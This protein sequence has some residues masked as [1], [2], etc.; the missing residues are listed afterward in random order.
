[1]DSKQQ[2]KANTIDMLRKKMFIE[3]HRPD[4]PISAT[5]QSQRSFPSIHMRSTTQ[6]LQ[7]ISHLSRDVSH[8]LDSN[9]K[10]RSSFE[11]HEAKLHEILGIKH[12]SRKLPSSLTELQSSLKLKKGKDKQDEILRDLENMKLKISK[13]KEKLLQKVIS[14][15]GL[16]YRTQ[17]GLIQ[18]QLA[19]LY[20]QMTKKGKGSLTEIPRFELDLGAPSGRKEV[21]IIILWLETMVNTHVNEPKDITLEEKVKRAQ[22]IYTTCFKEV[23][24]QVSTH[25]LE[26]GILMQKIWNAQIDIYCAK[27]DTRILEIDDMKRRLEKFMATAGAKYKAQNDFFEKAV[28]EFKDVIRGKDKEIRTLMVKVEE[29]KAQAERDRA[30]YIGGM[31]KGSKSAKKQVKFEN[32]VRDDHETIEEMVIFNR[33]PLVLVGYYDDDGFFHKQKAIQPYK[34][35]NAVKFYK[36]EIVKVAEKFEKETEMIRVQDYFLNKDTQME[37]DFCDR[38]IQYPDERDLEIIRQHDIG[39]NLPVKKFVLNYVP[40]RKSMMPPKISIFDENMENGIGGGLM[41]GVQ[42]EDLDMRKRLSMEVNSAGGGT[43]KSLLIENTMIHYAAEG[44]LDNQIVNGPLPELSS[45]QEPGI[46][47]IKAAVQQKSQAK[48]K[49]KS[50]NINQKTSQNK[51]FKQKSKK[52]FVPSEK[53]SNPEAISNEKTSELKI[54]TEKNV[55]Q[56]E[57]DD[58]NQSFEEK[59][60]KQQKHLLNSEK[61]PKPHKKSKIYSQYSLKKSSR[62][63]SYS[64]E[65]SENDSDDLKIS[66]PHGKSPKTTN[67]KSHNPKA[68]KKNSE[69]LEQDDSQ[70]ITPR[71][72]P[73]NHKK[74][75]KLSEK[76]VKQPKNPLNSS[77]SSDSDYKKPHNDS[78]SSENEDN[79]LLRVAQKEKTFRKSSVPVSPKRD[80]EFTSPSANKAKEIPKDKWENPSKTQNYKDKTKITIDTSVNKHPNIHVTEAAEATED[81]KSEYCQV[82]LNPVPYEELSSPQVHSTIHHLRKILKDISNDPLRKESLL[83]DNT[84]QKR[85]S[86]LGQ[87]IFGLFPREILGIEKK[88]ESGCIQKILEDKMCQTEDNYE[89]KI[90]SSTNLQIPKAAAIDMKSKTI[91]NTRSHISAA[92]RSRKNH[93]T[94]PSDPF[95]KS[96]NNS[97]NLKIVSTNKQNKSL[98]MPDEFA[99]GQISKKLILSH[100]GQK[101]LQMIILEIRAMDKVRSEMSIKSLMKAINSVYLE[102][103]TLSKENIN[104]IK[105]ET[106]MILYDM[107]MNRYGLKIVAEN[108]FKQIVFSSYFYKDSY[109]RVKNFIRFLGLEDDYQV[110]DWN[111]YLNCIDAIEYCN[112]GKNIFNEDTAVDHYSMLPRVIQCVHTIFDGKLP[113]NVIEKILEVVQNMKIEETQNLSKRNMNKNIIES[114]NTDMFLI[115]MMGYYIEAKDKILKKLFP[116]LDKDEFVNEEDFGVMM[117]SFKQIDSENSTK[118]FEK[119][120][121]N[122]R[123]EDEK[124]DRVIKGRS[125]LAIVFEYSLTDI[126]ELFKQKA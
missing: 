46:S 114:V 126:K 11:D 90:I 14:E 6:T 86:E 117:K 58:K 69:T 116:S 45:I 84:S 78:E 110:E 29:V 47:E 102:K 107:L 95:I 105:Y 85:A 75:Y 16:L 92:I 7:K 99:L 115:M 120:C 25:C 54:L 74:S 87:I 104:Y 89:V 83:K 19:N 53:P 1:M 40:G 111:F 10:I 4:S 23:I 77:N 119:Y 72:T 51:N 79:I 64:S 61:K 100:P 39:V 26:R 76:I 80:S 63:N 73:K 122:R 56:T 20:E 3:S 24:R 96:Q 106:C 22:L 28:H 103:T 5:I 44:V 2:D 48:K 88:N 27:E 70:D 42:S 31:G 57:I 118:V 55:P 101:L 52:S 9:T 37:Y 12:K 50:K 109:I 71:K 67:F 59:Q 49:G 121:I 36:D 91:K 60:G 97:K 17:S 123:A 124:V 112:I 81:N 113:E 41:L 108:K 15:G 93:Q 18:P 33:I 94:N 8:R 32:L 34:G 35:K 82:D 65:S 125:V 66:S 43:P 68:S 13:H 98:I 30:L 62:Q 21:E 38:S